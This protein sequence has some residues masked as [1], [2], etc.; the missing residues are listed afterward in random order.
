MRIT[1]PASAYP[2][3][4][5][6]P[7]ILTVKV[8]TLARSAF[9]TF[10]QIEMFQPGDPSGVGEDSFAFAV[11]DRDAAKQ[12]GSVEYPGGNKTV[13]ISAGSKPLIHKQIDVPVAPKHLRL[14]SSGHDFDGPPFYGGLNVPIDAPAAMPAGPDSGLNASGEWATGTRDNPPAHH[15]GAVRHPLR[16]E[17]SEWRCPLPG[18]RKC[19]GLGDRARADQ[20]VLSESERSRPARPMRRAP[21][22]QEPGERGWEDRRHSDRG[23]PGAQR[24]AP[25]PPQIAGH[26]GTDGSCST[27]FPGRRFTHS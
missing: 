27:T 24:V 21:C 8:R 14:W 1:A 26:R 2:S 4:N 18:P 23:R 25:G 19:L 6:T 7:F 9:V 12:L 10:A 20:E 22:R 5:P 3:L 13:S 16:P 11:Y 15:L 17:C